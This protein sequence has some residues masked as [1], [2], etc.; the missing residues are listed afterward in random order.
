MKDLV[1]IGIDFS[2]NKPAATIFKDNKYHFISWPY[3]LSN[4]LLKIY[5]SSPITVIKR[6]DDK[7]K[8]S[9]SSENMRYELINSKYIANLIYESLKPYVSN[10]TYIAFEGFSYGSGGNIGLQLSGYKYILMDVLSQII[11]IS[12]MYTYAPTTIKKT[13]GCSKKGMNKSDMI[14]AFINDENDSEFRIYLKQ[15]SD[16][17]KKKG[18]KNWVDH[19]DDFVDSFFALQTLKLKCGF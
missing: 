8:G 10:N 14:N 12:N 18:G 17:F 15:N 3:N 1:L 11:P 13:A 2:I 5:T 6:T 9:V 7:E 16:L 4:S 19:L